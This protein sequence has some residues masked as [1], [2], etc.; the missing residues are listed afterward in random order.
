M[1]NLLTIFLRN[2]HAFKNLQPS[3]IH[4]NKRVFIPY[5]APLCL[6]NSFI[7]PTEQGQPHEGGSSYGPSPPPPHIALNSPYAIND[8]VYIENI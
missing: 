7:F 5:W 8:V 1:L 6:E 3:L 4:S 2:R